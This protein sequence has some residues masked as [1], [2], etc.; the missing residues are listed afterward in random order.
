MNEATGILLM[1]IKSFAMIPEAYFFPTACGD[2]GGFNLT[3]WWFCRPG[4][5]RN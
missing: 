1:N 2:L 4:V 3:V 5:P